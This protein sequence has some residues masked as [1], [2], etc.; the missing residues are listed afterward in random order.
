MDLL[1]LQTRFVYLSVNVHTV[2]CITRMD[3]QS[4]S[5][6]RCFFF[7]LVHVVLLV[8]GLLCT[9]YGIVFWVAAHA[10]MCLFWN[11]T[12]LCSSQYHA[13]IP[14]K[15]D[16]EQEMGLLTSALIPCSCILKLHLL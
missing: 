3:E 2:Y 14:P 11:E 4:V 7:F 6:C 13:W 9:T 16:A 8:I 1:V 12:F 10:P 15:T 5:V